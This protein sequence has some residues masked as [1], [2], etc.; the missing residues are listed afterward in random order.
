MQGSALIFLAL[1]FQR[2]LVAFSALCRQQ[3]R[4]GYQRGLTNMAVKC[5][6]L[7]LA[8]NAMPVLL[9]GVVAL[10][11]GLKLEA[12][13]GIA[14]FLFSQRPDAAIDILACD[15]RLD[16]LD[17]NEILLVQRAQALEPHFEFFDIN[18]ELLCLQNQPSEWR[19][20]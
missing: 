4:A 9:V 15:G 20:L 5:T 3:I 2:V 17:A 12:F 1:G 19:D 8:K 6:Q 13:G 10:D 16:F 7:D 14:N 11:N 18:V